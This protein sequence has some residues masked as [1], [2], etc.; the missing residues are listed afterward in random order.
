VRRLVLGAGLVA[1]AD[2]LGQVLGEVADAPVSVFRSGEHALGV[3]PVAG[4]CDVQRLVVVADHGE[5]LVP[6]GQDFAGSR[7]DVGGDRRFPLPFISV[8]LIRKLRLK[9]NP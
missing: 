2:V 1:V 4:F 9:P 5:C 6:G 7:I 3:E 8:C